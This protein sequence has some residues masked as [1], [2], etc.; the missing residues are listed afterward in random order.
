MARYKKDII[1][2]DRFEVV[3]LSP[4]ST[5]KEIAF[6]LNSK[7]DIKSF[8]INRI[9]GRGFLIILDKGG[10]YGLQT[11]TEAKTEMK[12]YLKGSL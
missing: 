9:E 5:D 10:S 6:F 1:K 7:Q 4:L 11:E 8:S 3:S 12:D 2:E